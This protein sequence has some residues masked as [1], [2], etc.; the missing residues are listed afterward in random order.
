MPAHLAIVAYRALVEGRP[1]G[2]VDIQVR[3]FDD[4]DPAAIR[5]RIE[6]E[7]FM[8]YLNPDDEVVCWELS[9]VISIEPFEP[10]ES[11]EEVVGFITSAED[12]SELA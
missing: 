12:F 6:S 8:S 9:D 5:R 7:S 3:W 11:G 4:D 10:R 1:T 2:K